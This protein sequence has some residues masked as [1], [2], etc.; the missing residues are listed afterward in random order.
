[1]KMNNMKTWLYVEVSLERLNLIR[2][3]T[4]DLHDAFA[5]PEDDCLFQVRFP[6]D[7]PYLTPD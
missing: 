3:G 1:M 7:N 5:Y 4:I 6:Y 2:S